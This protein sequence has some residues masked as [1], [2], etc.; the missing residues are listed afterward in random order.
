MTKKKTEPSEV[1][2]RKNEERFTTSDTKKM[3]S[4][5]LASNLNRGWKEDFIDEDTGEV[6]SIERFER[7]ESRGTLIDESIEA[8]IRFYIQSG[9]ITEVEVSN[10]R[11][12]AIMALSGSMWP[13]SVTAKIGEKKRRL[14]LYAETAQMAL[15]IAQDYI[16]LNFSELF[17]FVSI[18]TFDWC[19]FIKDSLKKNEDEMVEREFYKIEVEV[20]KGDIT[21]PY[22]FV[23][24]TKDVDTGMIVINDWIANKLKEERLNSE[25]SESTEFGTT[26]KSGVIIPCYRIVEK[27]FSE[28]Y[29]VKRD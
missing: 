22:T 9:D 13:W 14:L 1:Q 2:T 6:V 18:K 10:Q 19:I 8:Q 29:I 7:I 17:H 28:A 11:R 20:F 5:Y 21:T 26:V 24:Q 4:K 23:L 25:L 27:E 3:L 12:E 16:E 15:E